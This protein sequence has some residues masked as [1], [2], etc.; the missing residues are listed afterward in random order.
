MRREYAY[1]CFNVLWEVTDMP[2]MMEG[3]SMRKSANLDTIYK[4][5]L[6]IE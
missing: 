6:M 4:M 3:G 2:V 1:C 5:P